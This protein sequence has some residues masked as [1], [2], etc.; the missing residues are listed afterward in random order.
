MKALSWI[1][2]PLW[3]LLVASGQKSFRANPLLGSA[4]LNRLGLHVARVQVAERMAAARR[5]RLAS[6]IDSGL[7][8]QY[9][10]E[11]FTAIEGFLPAEEFATL[12]RDLEEVPL[13]SWERREGATVTRRGSLDLPDI[14]GRPALQRLMASQAIPDLL[15]YAA[16]CGGEPLIHL[17]TVLAEGDA[18]R[19]DPQNTLHMDTFHSTAKAWLYLQDVGI[20]D[21][22][23]MYVPGSHR[24]T[25]ERLEWELELSACAAS[26]HDPEIAAGSFRIADE[27]L[28]DLG[29]PP[30]RALAVPA[31]TL[32]VANTH[33]FHARKAS[34][35]PTAR[36]EIYGSLRRNPFLPVTGFHLH[37]LPG[38]K[39]HLS[40]RQAQID[41]VLARYLGLKGPWVAVPPK[42]L[43]DPASI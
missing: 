41:A 36:S 27:M 19:P 14:K 22:P 10:R 12:R 32:V 30:A 43:Y 4:A 17:Q 26:H 2:A 16:G 20:E 6:R 18:L 9:E 23:L 31:N 29:Y 21:G 8:A 38:L 13:A 35:R 1:A 39:G 3:P 7:R 34:A 24:L 5:A 28:A 37:S 11:G 33:G 25:R 15:R 42:R 40:T